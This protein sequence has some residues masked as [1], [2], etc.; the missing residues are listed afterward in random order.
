M[1]LLSDGSVIA[2][3]APAEGRFLCRIFVCRINSEI[4]VEKV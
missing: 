4:S 3:K 2:Q 1:F